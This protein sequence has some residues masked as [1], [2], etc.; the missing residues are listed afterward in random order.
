MIEPA[1]HTHTLTSNVRFGDSRICR[2]A[3]ERYRF[4]TGYC[5]LRF[6]FRRSPRSTLENSNSQL[7][8]RTETRHAHVHVHVT[9]RHYVRGTCSAPAPAPLASAGHSGL[10]VRRRALYSSASLPG[11]AWAGLGAENLVRKLLF[12][13]QTV[14]VSRPPPPPLHPLA[15]LLALIDFYLG[16]A[17]HL[18]RVLEAAVVEGGGSELRGA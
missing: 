1:P 8:N 7:T 3:G 16:G 9:T 17:G 15:P 18:L 14:P 2:C 13:V 11:E 4:L 5:G 6:R 12:S 10:A